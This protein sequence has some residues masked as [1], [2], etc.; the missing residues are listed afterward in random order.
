[1]VDLALYLDFQVKANIDAWYFDGSEWH[2]LLWGT[3]EGLG[4]RNITVIDYVESIK[5]RAGYSEKVALYVREVYGLGTGSKKGSGYFVLSVFVKQGATMLK[6]VTVTLKPLASPHGDNQNAT[7]DQRGIATFELT[8]G[9]Y[10]VKA[11]YD[12]KVKTMRVWLSDN[13][14]VGFEFQAPPLD[15][16]KLEGILIGIVV[17]VVSV[18]ALLRLRR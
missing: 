17:G 2:E 15:K 18:L 4:W 10:L 7:T 6:D 16:S 14:N 12:K 8:Y 5:L 3:H 9:S 11:Y 13:Q 1:M